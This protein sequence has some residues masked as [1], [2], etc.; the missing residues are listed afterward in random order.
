M[1]APTIHGFR[2]PFA[3]SAMLDA[4]GD[5]LSVIRQKDRLTWDVVGKVLG[6]SEDQAAKYADGTATMDFI[7]YR[8]GELAWGSRF[9]G[10][11]DRLLSSGAEEPCGHRTLSSLL[12]AATEISDA[13]K[14]NNICDKDIREARAELERARDDID[15]LLSRLGPKAGAA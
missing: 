9:T 12:R 5:D 4:L 3:A 2:F 7:S 15:S 13:L 14:D 1:R 8:R 6:R 11:L 10:T